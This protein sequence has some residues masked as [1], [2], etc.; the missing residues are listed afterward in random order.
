M[1]RQKQAQQ[2]ED[3]MVVLR[4]CGATLT[5]NTQESDLEWLARVL[6]EASLYGMGDVRT[7]PWVVSRDEWERLGLVPMSLM[8]DGPKRFDRLGEADQEAWRKLA[9]VCMW[10]MPSF[11]DRV[12]SRFMEQ[13]SA[14]EAV[15]RRE[16]KVGGS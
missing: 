5:G 2:I 15:W 9:R 11:A 3:A 4:N 8:G 7:V 14:L 16:T 13:A 6:F 10:V 12:G 1:A